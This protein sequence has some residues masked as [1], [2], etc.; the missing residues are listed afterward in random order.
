MTGNN[1]NYC[2]VAF[3]IIILIATIQWIVDGRK[4]YRGPT[5]D[6]VALGNG[7]VVGIVPD[8]VGIEAL[9]GTVE[10]ERKDMKV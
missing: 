7:E 5:I 2:S 6:Q 9:D 4:N 8:E 10:G 1:M 3:G